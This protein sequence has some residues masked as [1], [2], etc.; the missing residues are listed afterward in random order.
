MMALDP[1]TVLHTGGG[2]GV[3]ATVE[4][5]FAVAVL[6]SAGARRG[7]ALAGPREAPEARLAAAFARE[8]DRDGEPT[9][10]DGESSLDRPVE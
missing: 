1:G 8:G 9:G 2:G 3:W 4:V 7:A 5:A 6:G 10:G